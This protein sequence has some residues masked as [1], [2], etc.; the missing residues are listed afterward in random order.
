MSGWNEWVMAGG[1][2]TAAWGD[3]GGPMNGC[4]GLAMDWTDWMGVRPPVTE[5][6]SVA[7]IENICIEVYWIT[8]MPAR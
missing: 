2:R 3:G 1:W 7:S 6:R 4:P 5:Q 8:C